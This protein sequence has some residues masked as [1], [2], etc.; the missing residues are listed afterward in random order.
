MDRYR[1]K[2][3]WR[4]SCGIFCARRFRFV[5]ERRNV[6]PL[7]NLDPDRIVLPGRQIVALE[8]PAQPAGFD[9]DDGIGLRIEA[10]IPPE[11][12]RGDAVGFDALGA[13]SERFLDDILKETAVALGCVEFLTPNA[14]LELRPN[15]V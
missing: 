1:G 8:G 11:H 15:R 6:G 12:R 5:L 7:G 3:G 9:S 14:T 10:R 2:G 13:L 4:R